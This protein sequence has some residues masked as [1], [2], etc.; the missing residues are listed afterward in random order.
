MP[1]VLDF[2]AT[3]TSLEIFGFDL[4]LPCFLSMVLGEGKKRGPLPLSLFDCFSSLYVPTKKLLTW[5]CSHRGQAQSC[6][7]KQST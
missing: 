5:G 6:K 4:C 7:V 2:T 1:F 3:G